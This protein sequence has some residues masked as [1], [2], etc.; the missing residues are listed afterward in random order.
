[1]IRISFRLP[2][3]ILRLILRFNEDKGFV[4]TVGDA[5]RRVEAVAKVALNLVVVFSVLLDSAK[6]ASQHTR[7]AADAPFFVDNDAAGHRVFGNS[8]GKADVYAT[9]FVAL[10][11]PE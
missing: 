1:M 5:S 11:A 9:R 3:E 7:P 6:R 10:P 2:I 8:T 4:R